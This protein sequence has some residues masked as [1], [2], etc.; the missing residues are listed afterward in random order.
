M[1]PTGQ[2][3]VALLGTKFM[4]RAHSHAWRTAGRFFDLP[5]EPVLRVVA[6]RDRDATR[7]FGEHWGWERATTRWRDAVTDPEVDLVDVATPNDKH[8]D[9][10]IAALEAGKHVAC[11]KPLAGTLDDARAG[12]GSFEPIRTTKLQ[13]PFHQHFHQHLSTAARPQ[14]GTAGAQRVKARRLAKP[15][16]VSPRA[17]PLGR[18]AEESSACVNSQW[19]RFRGTPSLPFDERKFPPKGSC[20]PSPGL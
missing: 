18:V 16:A 5:R 12:P 13:I 15:S 14:A 6:G 8:A 17:Q 4:G 2:L 10:A 3:N 11:E 7:A 1:S 20:L 19:A 9:Q